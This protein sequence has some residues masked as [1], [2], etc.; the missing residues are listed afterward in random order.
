M[1]WNM[2]NR[3]NNPHFDGTNLY[4]RGGYWIPPLSLLY[5]IHL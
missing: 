2:R 3:K 1:Q 5:F 4:E